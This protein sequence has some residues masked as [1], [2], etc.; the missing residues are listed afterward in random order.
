MHTIRSR[1]KLVVS[2]DGHGVVNHAGSRLLANLADATPLTSAF[3]DALHRLRPRG[4]G[5]DPGRMAVDLAV[6]LADRGEA[7]RGLAVLRDQRD[8]FGPVASTPTAWRVLAGIDT[9]NLNAR[10]Q[11]EPLPEVAWLQTVGCADQARR[12]HAVCARA[13]RC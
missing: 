10:G 2:A 11:P 9:N 12:V 13:R 1:P 4:T 6:M 8:V 3:S 7:F 5:H